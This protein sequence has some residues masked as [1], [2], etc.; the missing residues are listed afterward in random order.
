MKG[1][2]GFLFINIFLVYMGKYYEVFFC[3]FKSCCVLKIYIFIFIKVL[4]YCR[5]LNNKLFVF[6]LKC[7][8]KVD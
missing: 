3:C 1:L 4:C 7:I 5:F 6:E 8:I 2:I